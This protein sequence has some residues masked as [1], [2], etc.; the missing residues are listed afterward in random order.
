MFR[1]PADYTGLGVVCPVCDRMLR[2]PRA[3]ESI[4]SLVQDDF[5]ED[6]PVVNEVAR[7]EE[8]EF[9]E[10]GEVTLTDLSQENPTEVAPPVPV[11]TATGGERR[12][13]K[14]KRSSGIDVESGWQKGEEKKMLRFSRR[15][16]I[17]WWIAGASML[18][19]VVVAIILSIMPKDQ[20]QSPV[21]QAP[22]LIT[23]PMTEEDEEDQVREAALRQLKAEREA[24]AVVEQLYQA[25]SIEVLLPLLR[26]TEGVREKATQFHAVKPLKAGSMD[27][28]EEISSIPNHDASAFFVQVRLNDYATEGVVVVKVGEKFLVDWESWVGWCEMSYETIREK[29]PTTPTEVRVIAE[30]T[31]YYNFDFPNSSES[32]WQSYRLKF[33]DGQKELYGYIM[34]TSE[35]NG[36]VAPASD[37]GAKSLVLRIRYRDESSHPSQVLIDSVVTDGWVKDLP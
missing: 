36:L 14:R 34:R 30:P 19:V 13:R 15:V 25:D 4:P 11:S 5:T 28:I 12:R 10:L 32:E 35:L 22:Q 1:V 9:D 37:Q 20:P 18:V 31:M 7:I 17:G 2:I 8:M 27:E 26:P 33:P 16:P 29:K 6:A 3:G 21:A 23:L 24:R